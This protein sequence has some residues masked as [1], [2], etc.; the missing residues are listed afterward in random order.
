MD[1]VLKSILLDI[2]PKMDSSKL[3]EL[4]DALITA[5]IQDESDLCWIASDD[6]QHLLPP[7]QVRKLIAALNVKY[8][9]HCYSY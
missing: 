4:V 9:M 8:G 5:G 3:S 6:I 7:V 2:F 1:C